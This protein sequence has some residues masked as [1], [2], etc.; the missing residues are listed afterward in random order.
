M[1]I[2]LAFTAKA[3]TDGLGTE[4][5]EPVVDVDYVESIPV[6]PP[7][8]VTHAYLLLHGYITETEA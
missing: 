6:P 5:A 1:A 4:D 7:L 8:T 2:T 3:E